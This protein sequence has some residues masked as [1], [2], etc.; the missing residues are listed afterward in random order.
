MHDLPE[1]IRFVIA[2]AVNTGFA[3]ILFTLGLF[4]LSDPLQ[5][6]GSP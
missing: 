4:L 1:P 6:M 5:A 3:Y 2:G